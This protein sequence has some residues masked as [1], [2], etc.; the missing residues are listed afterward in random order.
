VARGRG[1]GDAVGH[2]GQGVGD[3]DAADLSQRQE[4]R[5]GEAGCG[6]PQRPGATLS[7]AQLRRKA[8]R[9]IASS[10]G[11]GACDDDFHPSRVR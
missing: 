1:T 5:G 6:R 4:A 9:G 8:T 7:L 11:R 2:S 3:A 10:H